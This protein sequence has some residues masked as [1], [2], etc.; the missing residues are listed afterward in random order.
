LGPRGPG[1]CHSSLTAR[2][3]HSLQRINRDGRVVC[4]PFP[5]SSEK[6]QPAQIAS[7]SPYP[8][9]TRGHVVLSHRRVI[10][11]PAIGTD[12]LFHNRQTG[13]LQ[14][15]N[16][17][18]IP[19]C[20]FAASANEVFRPRRNR[21]F[22]PVTAGKPLHKR[23]LESFDWV[24]DTSHNKCGRHGLSR[25]EWVRN[26][27]KGRHGLPTLIADESIP[28]TIGCSTQSPRP[29]WIDCRMTH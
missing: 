22:M 4:G 3:P 18:Y 28:Y 16:R 12:L 9:G 11:A 25:P 1:G 10:A 26:P 29:V 19:H 5:H 14:F 2:E 17:A 8:A 15:E 6:P 13:R 24:V 21:T 20:D 7:I 27:D 23:G